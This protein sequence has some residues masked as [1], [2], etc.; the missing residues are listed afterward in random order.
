M[1]GERLDYCNILQGREWS[2]RGRARDGGLALVMGGAFGELH[3][4]LS[5]SAS[6][7]QH[8]NYGGLVPSSIPSPERKI[9]TKVIFGD[10]VFTGYLNPNG[11]S[12]S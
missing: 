12:P 6:L 9:G 4:P 11:V 3:C 2:G 5:F 8:T 7:G 1:R 10:I